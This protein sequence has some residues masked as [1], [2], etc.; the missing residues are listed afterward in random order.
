M[1]T[2][3]PDELHTTM[4]CWE[5]GR[6]CDPSSLPPFVKRWQRNL[7]VKNR[8]FERLQRRGIFCTLPADVV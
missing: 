3:D 7:E 2:F 6:R 4:T 5:D 1:N 8:M